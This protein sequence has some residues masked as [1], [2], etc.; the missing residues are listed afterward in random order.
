MTIITAILTAL[1]KL[2]DLLEKFAG[3]L[4]AQ[5]EIARQKKAAQDMQ[6]AVDKAAKT[7]DTSDIDNLFKG[8]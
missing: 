8:Q 6:N 4:S 3:W 1:P 7:K 2:L 5:V